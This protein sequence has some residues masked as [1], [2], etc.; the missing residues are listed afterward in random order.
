[1][2]NDGCCS[3]LIVLIVL[4]FGMQGNECTVAPFKMW[5]TVEC[6]YY[7]FNILFVYVYYKRLLKRRRDDI[8]FQI[9][10]CILNLIHSG[11]LIYGNI[12][13]F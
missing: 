8:R 5:I 10:N 11:W 6:S 13:Y 12:L 4:L 2:V 3:L 7:A 9:A 1:M